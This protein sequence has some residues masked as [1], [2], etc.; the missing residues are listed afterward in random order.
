MSAILILENLA[1]QGIST[2]V[3]G[4]KIRLTPKRLVTPELAGRIAAHKIDLIT[5]LNATEG[6]ESDVGRCP[7][8]GDS[9]TEK[10][11]FDGY[12]NL[13]CEA[14][15]QCFGCRPS[16]EVNRA[17]SS[18]DPVPVVDASDLHGRIKAYK[19]ELLSILPHN[20]EAPA[21]ARTECELPQQPDASDF[22]NANDWYWE[23]IDEADRERPLQPREWP[24]PC[25]WC[26]GRTVHSAACDEL[27]RGWIPIFPFG[28]YRGRRAD[29]V[30]V[31][32]IDCVLRKGIGDDD[33]RAGLQLWLESDA[34]DGARM[35]AKSNS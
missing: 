10:L 15:D 30:P 34:T 13:E 31:G 19:P 16:S 2:K 25:A 32:Y 17:E 29:N 5:I 23:H 3:V 1:Q 11:T 33:F 35:I 7:R 18:T 8:C 27:R 4:D 14:C 22:M 20:R 6:P 26:G 12:L 24:A 21:V 9:L 28:Q